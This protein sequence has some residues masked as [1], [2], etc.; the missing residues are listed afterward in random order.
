MQP[1]RPGMKVEHGIKMTHVELLDERILD[2][3]RIAELRESLESVIEKNQDG[4]MLINFVNV[5][6]MT[7][8]MLG[9]LVRVHKKV[10]ELGGKLELCNVDPSIRKIFEITQLTKVLDIS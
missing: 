7:S 3:Q 8:A 5:Q 6:F 4:R 1:E 2:E 9:L 10:C